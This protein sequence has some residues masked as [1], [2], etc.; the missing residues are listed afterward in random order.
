[1]FFMTELCGR[2]GISRVLAEEYVGLEEIDNS[3]LD[4]CFAPLHVGRLYEEDLS[5]LRR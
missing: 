1:M 2:F 4:G 3:L 5:R